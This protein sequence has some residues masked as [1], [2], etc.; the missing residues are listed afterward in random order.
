MN[1][2][3]DHFSTQAAQY[4]RYRPLYPLELYEDLV[5]LLEKPELAWD[6]ATGN[7]QVAVD[8]TRFINQVIATDASEDQISNSIPHEKIQY[9]VCPAEK[10]N[11]KT[12]TI[13]LITVGQALHWFKFEEF[14]QEAKRVLK[15]GGVIAVWSYNLLHCHQAVDELLY[16]FYDRKI[17]KYW[18]PE[19][20]LVEAGYENILFPFEEIKMHEYKMQTEWNLKQLTGYLSTWSAV[21][22][23]IEREGCDPV[24]ELEKELAGVW[25][26]QKTNRIS[27]PLSLRVGRI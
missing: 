16:E 22:R 15:P 14:Y 1:K 10:T 23:F 18:P 4:A 27:W 17:G 13:D 20:R 26:G 19:R 25:G 24:P 2:F 8:L 9:H 6:C 11:L 21:Q 7:G 3:K 5:S 12:D